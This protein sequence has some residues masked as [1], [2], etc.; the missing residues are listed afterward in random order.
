MRNY[1]ASE[2]RQSGKREKNSPN[3]QASV[4]HPP[5]SSRPSTMRG[6][7][8]RRP[9]RRSADDVVATGRGM[10]AMQVVGT[11][12]GASRGGSLS[13]RNHSS[14]HSSVNGGGGAATSRSGSE[15]S[16]HCGRNGASAE[17]GVSPLVQAF[18]ACVKVFCTSVAPCYALPWVRGEESHTTGS[19]FAALL[20]SGERRILVHAQVLDNHTL[21]QVR[22]VSEAQKYVAQV[23]CVGYDV[24]VGVL[25]VD[26]DAFWSNMP[27]LPLPMGL[28]QPMSE[29]I[30]AGFLTGGEELSTT[31]G[32]VN[33]I[34]LGGNTRELCV[35]M[36]AAI[37]PSNS[38]GPILNSN[39]QVVGMACSGSQH[40][41]GLIIPLPV[42]H[43][44]LEVRVNVHTKCSRAPACC[45]FA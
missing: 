43:T 13:S 3:V 14:A 28:P 9:Q 37:N 25:R 31:R 35:Q 38:G 11:A 44:F 19:G 30:T 21:V 17:S 5:V 40:A 2:A 34:M 7:A 23:E 41:P 22:R 24:D 1:V 8:A 15:D 32:V 27:L 10:A 18:G 4:L 36:D 16:L 33:R 6:G 45:R 12:P 39:G 29:V 20:P 26:D 42:I